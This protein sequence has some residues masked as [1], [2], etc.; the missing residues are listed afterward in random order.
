MNLHY[1]KNKKT[2]LDLQLKN[3]YDWDIF[4]SAYNDNERVKSVFESVDAKK[5]YWLVLPE[6][7]YK[8]EDLPS[9]TDAVKFQD[10][11]EAY[12]VHEF[13]ENHIG[14]DVLKNSR[15]CI[16]ITGFLRPHILKLVHYLHCVDIKRFD[17]L[18]TEPKQYEKKENSLYITLHPAA[19]VEAD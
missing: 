19:V 13:I 18:Y 2:E 5:K 12:V 11:N 1:L 17:V 7:D 9:N 10:R 3:K 16:D 6:Y 8:D 15:I 14:L 4:I